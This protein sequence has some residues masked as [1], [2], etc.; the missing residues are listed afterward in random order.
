MRYQKVYTQIWNDEKF[1]KLSERG[2]SLFLYLLTAP[3]SNLIGCYVLRKGYVMEDLE[4]TSEGLNKA[5]NEVL[6]EGLISYDEK[7]G[8]VLLSSGVGGAGA[9][10][11]VQRA[12]AGDANAPQV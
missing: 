4:W 6:T 2:K 7:G 11:Q 3:H 1:R 10:Q 12:V 9:L 8:V 5:L